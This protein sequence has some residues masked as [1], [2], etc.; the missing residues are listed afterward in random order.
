MAVNMLNEFQAS[1]KKVAIPFTTASGSLVSTMLLKHNCHLICF[2]PIS[3]TCHHIRLTFFSKQYLESI[4]RQWQ[5]HTF[6]FFS[7]VIF[8]HLKDLEPPY[9]FPMLKEKDLTAISVTH[10]LLLGLDIIGFISKPR[11]SQVYILLVR[12]RN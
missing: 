7:G 10:F 8:I 6:G 1:S 2:I 12:D 5:S 11:P 4:R 9:S 3:C